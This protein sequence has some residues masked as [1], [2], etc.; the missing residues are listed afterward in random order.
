MR[1][2]W[3]SKRHVRRAFPNI[4]AAT[5]PGGR[6]ICWLL[7][8]ALWEPL[9][10]SSA[11]FLVEHH[12][13]PPANGTHPAGGDGPPAPKC[14]VWPALWSVDADPAPGPHLNGQLLHLGVHGLK[15]HWLRRALAVGISP[16]A[17]KD[18]SLGAPGWLGLS[19]RPSLRPSRSNRAVVRPEAP[20][21]HFSVRHSWPFGGGCVTPPSTGISV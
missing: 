6:L 2:I 15:G 8:D 5:N 12:V 21:V 4:S 7:S 17:K 1:D 3:P 20:A 11:V 9:T 10:A 19:R 18:A 13:G 16:A 14:Y